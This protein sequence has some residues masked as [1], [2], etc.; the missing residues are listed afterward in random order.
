MDLKLEGKQIQ[1]LSPRMIQS[2]Q[3]LQ[4]DSLE[5]G[6]FLTELAQENPVLELS[7]PSRLSAPLSVSDFGGERKTGAQEEDTGMEARSGEPLLEETLA[8]HLLSQLSGLSL[9]HRQEKACQFIIA[10][11]DASGY[12]DECPEALARRCVF[13][14]QE[15]EDALLAVQRLDPPGVGAENLCECLC[16]QLQRMD[17][18]TRLAQRIVE[19]GLDAL[20]KCHYSQLAK[21]LGAGQKDIIAACDLIRSL[22]PRPGAGFSGREIPAYITPDLSIVCS[23]GVL[24]LTLN[25]AQLPSVTI[26]SYYSRLLKQTEEA[27]V[28]AYLEEK[29]QQANW[30]VKCIDQRRATLLR[31]AQSILNRQRAFFESPDGHLVPMRM[32]DVARELG[33]HESTVSRAIR[34]KYLQCSRGI[35][36][37]SSFF[38]ARLSSARQQDDCVS[39]EKAKAMLSALIAEENRDRPLSDQKLCDLMEAAGCSLSRRTVAKY[40]D[41]LGIPPAAARKR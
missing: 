37:L 14:P 16:L 1:T 8:F 41:Q 27:D 34:G 11:L 30:V 29:I 20:A 5:L 3:I 31:C 12:L 19:N 39:A 36:P 6:R 15:L 22:N 35:F 21:L 28:R 10:S 40:R 7:E 9:T 2:M 26:S 33:V 4:M 23:D 25:D 38:T 18:D 32:G 24:S 17:G 13:T